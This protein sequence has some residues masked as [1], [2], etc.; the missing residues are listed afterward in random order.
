MFLQQA[1]DITHGLYVKVDTLTGLT[2]HLIVCPPSRCPPSLFMRSAGFSLTPKPDLS[3]PS[4]SSLSWITAPPVSA[5]RSLLMSALSVLSVS[6]VRSS[7]FFLFPVRPTPTKVAHRGHLAGVMNFL[8][9]VQCVLSF[10]CWTFFLQLR[11]HPPAFARLAS[12]FVFFWIRIGAYG[13][14]VTLSMSFPGSGVLTFLYCSSRLVGK[15]K[16]KAKV[17]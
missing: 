15:A 9:Q 4:L 14:F 13:L 5:I 1:C 8:S 10:K 6:Q 3:A 11:A 2:Q 17:K 16:K 12:M 7:S